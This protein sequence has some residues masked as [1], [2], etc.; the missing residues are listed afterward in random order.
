MRFCYR[1]IPLQGRTASN[2]TAEDGIAG[3][4]SGRRAPDPGPLCLPQEMTHQLVESGRY[5]TRED[6]TVVLQPFFEKVD[7]PK[8]PVSKANVVDKWGGTQMVSSCF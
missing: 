7:M 4:P 6:F 5:D 3:R 1:V 2:P 8:T